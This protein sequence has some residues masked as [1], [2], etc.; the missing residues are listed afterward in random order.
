M[1]KRTYTPE[2]TKANSMINNLIKAGKIE[3]PDNCVVCD[4]ASHIQAHHPDP[5]DKPLEVVWS[6]QQCHRKLD[7]RLIQLQPWMIASYYH[8]KTRDY[9]RD[10]RGN[11]HWRHRNGYEASEETR[12]RMSQARQEWWAK[13]RERESA[14]TALVY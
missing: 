4:K 11:R 12:R 10:A 6:C 9:W 13:K 7:K 2:Q 3:R 1:R 5:G 8:L 14:S